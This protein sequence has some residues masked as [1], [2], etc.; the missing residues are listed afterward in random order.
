[1]SELQNHIRTRVA[2]ALQP[3]GWDA[4][5]VEAALLLQPPKHREHG[6]VALG[7]FQ[8]ARLA[9]T[10][11]PALAAELARAIEPD[12]VL[13]AVAAAG[14]FVNFRYRRA[15]LARHAVTGVLR[16][17]PPFGPAPT[18]DQVVVLDFS[19]PNIAKPFHIGHM[20][21]TVIGNA[22]C[23]IHRHL[24]HRAIGINHLG[25]W[26]MPFAKMMTAFMRWGDEAELR[27]S[28]MRYM[29][30][31]YKRF[32]AEVGPHPELEAEAAAHFRA[33]ES[34]AD[35]AERR[36]WQFLRDESLRA[37]QGPYDR[38]GV[39]FDTITG[40]SF[41]E[42][43]M[44]DA[45]QRVEQAGVLEES[46]GAQVVWLKEHGIQEPCI[47]RKSDGTTLY[48][49]RDL[50]AVFWR[51]QQYRPNRILYVVGAEQKLHF[52]QLKAMLKKM[53]EPIADAVEHV[54]FGLVLAKDPESGRWEKFASRAGNAVF[55][56]EILD[57]S[58]QKVRQI[59]AE[60]NPE[61]PD[62]DQVAEQ[63]GVSAVV[64]NDL[65]NSR[66]KDVKFD[67]E[68]MLN[69][70][71][72]TGPYVQ[73]ACARLSSILRK[74]VA[75]L[76]A[77]ERPPLDPDDL[78]G[79]VERLLA[80]TDFAQLADAERVLLGMLDYGPAVQRA[81]EQSEPSQLCAWAIAFAGEIHSYLRDHHVLSA[82]PAQRHARLALVAASRRLL[83]TS[84]HLLG[85]AA[86][87]RM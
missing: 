15:V 6:D 52:D 17:A 73:Y 30:D 36:M 47:L 59:I 1:M 56:D 23:R 11:P 35:N 78:D 42:D 7:C 66:I 37:F 9:G 18:G 29:F 87:D 14:P 46:K 8:L 25:D 43:K 13:E 34:G 31:L 12:D 28:P 45:L 61:L 55:L 67:W 22:L 24:G 86:P 65:K 81:A 5:A 20:R 68:T 62:A 58:V 57:E 38:L 70:E 10:S 72:E 76:P 75:E 71:G 64:F 83:Q 19:S 63:V 80:G 69:F 48:H 32:S 16:G 60:K 41:F 44:A 33:L 82:A 26:G 79:T 27:R 39:S 53:G 4:A 74:A 84:L 21:S 3:R 51:E 77:A 54:A 85:I 49:T 2:A 40:E 50:A